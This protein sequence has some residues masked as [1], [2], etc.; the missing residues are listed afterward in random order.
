MSLV[1]VACDEKVIEPEV[2]K[3]VG[4]DCESIESIGSFSYATP[5]NDAIVYVSESRTL[6]AHSNEVN[7]APTRYNVV[8][9]CHLSVDGVDSYVADAVSCVSGK[10]VRI[11]IYECA[12]GKFVHNTEDR[13]N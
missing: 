9:M 3:P 13:I 6:L 5:Y 7:G 12:D 4:A 11:V 2:Y 8:S 1:M 10:S